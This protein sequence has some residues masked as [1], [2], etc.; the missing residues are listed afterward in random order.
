MNNKKNIVK[1]R[2]L[3]NSFLKLCFATLVL[4]CYFSSALYSQ[5]TK[6]FGKITDFETK[7]PL[8]FVNV[9]FKGTVIGT[10]TDIDGKF[11]LE[12]GQAVDSIYVSFL[13]YT[14][15]F[16]AIEKRQSQNIDIALHSSNIQ[17]AEIT[18]KPG[19]NPAHALFKKVVSQKEKNNKENLNAYEYEVYNKV[20]FDIN[21]IPEKLRNR[22][23]F[24]KFGFVF[25]KIDSNGK[26]PYLPMFIT[27]TLSEVFYRKNP[28]ILKEKINAVK[29]SGVKNQ[30]INNFLGDV[31]QNTNV[32]DNYVSVFGKS[33]ISP[34]ADFGMLYYKYYLV[35]SAYLDNKW[36]YH[37]SFM[38]KRRQEPTFAGDFW[39]HDTTFAI[40]KINVSIASDANIN[41][42]NSFSASQNFELIDGVWMLTKD[43]LLVDFNVTDKSVGIYGKKN[44]S[45]KNFK[46]NDIKDPDFYDNSEDIIVLDDASEKPDDYW[47]QMRHDTLSKSELEIYELVDTIK[48]LPA[49]KSYVDVVSMMISGYKE[50]GKVEFGPYFT[51][52]SYNQIE[53]NRFKLGLRTSDKFSSRLM[54]DGYLAYGL[55]DQVFKYGGGFQY[56]LTKNIRQFIGA[57]YKYDMEQ[58]G[59]S[60]NALRQDNIFGSIRRFPFNKLTLVEEYKAFYERETFPGFSNRLTLKYRTLI[61]KGSLNYLKPIEDGDAQTQQNIITSEI[62]FKSRFAYKEKFVSG[63]FDRVS[64][65]TKYPVFQFYYTLGFKG[66]LGSDYKYQKVVLNISNYIKTQPFGYLDYS[67]E[68]GKIY[69]TLPFPLLE[70]HNGNETYSYDKLAFNMMNYF[71]FA[72]DKYFS[73]SFHQH[74][75]GFFLDKFP[76]IRRL[77][78]REIAFAKGVIGSLN[79]KNKSLMILPVNMST[80]EKP[81]VEAGFG[82]E[83]IFKILRV[84][85]IWRLTHL[86]KPNVSKFGIRATI[87][88]NF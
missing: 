76:I 52:Y 19:E 50:M 59:Q 63:E 71:E 36:C 11:L 20:E 65:G 74:F 13:G 68:L 56:F 82:V 53:G 46:L 49:F 2:F 54:L 28:K 79:E 64:L 75:N 22:K 16:L 48:S 12:T 60:P 27:E 67:F 10:T 61:P 24:K 9:V 21:N 25:D 51:T 72:S 45:Y 3:Q 40:K 44:T 23:I 42:V 5:N 58:L 26:K 69:G 70:L 87:A 18:V 85:G 39:V 8:P 78:W 33:F 73:A 88:I 84:D 37:L 80:L 66:V 7:E 31:Y 43:E 81:Y 62:L 1:A 77:K 35:D 15:I 17:L 86:D 30:S 55:K 47:T 38:P 4:S 57:S 6:V 34:L 29:I 41:Y 14:S 83:N 32:Y